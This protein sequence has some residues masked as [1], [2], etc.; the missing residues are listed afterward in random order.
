MATQI[1]PEQGLVVLVTKTFS[2]LD[3]STGSDPEDLFNLI[4]VNDALV[5]LTGPS[6]IDTLEM[7]TTGIYGGTDIPF[8]AGQSYTLRVKSVSLGEVQATTAVKPQIR[9]NSIKA[10]LYLNGFGDTL[11]QINYSLRDPA[12]KNYYMLNVQEVER[13]DLIRNAINPRAYTRLVEDTEF[14]GQ[15]FQEQFRVFPRDYSPGG[16]IA[17][18]LSNISEEYYNFVKLRLD[19]RYSFVEFLSEPVNYPSNII[20]GK[21]FFNLYVPD[22]RIFVFEERK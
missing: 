20:G 10:D 1:I 7:L 21:G 17:V 16:T 6:G 12:E 15:E 22:F 2:A 13:E 9:F 18:S 3:A 8:V 19:N 4:G 5:T 14:N 11:A